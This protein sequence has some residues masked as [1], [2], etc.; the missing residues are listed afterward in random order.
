MAAYYAFAHTYGSNTIDE[1]GDHI[2][3]VMVFATRKERDA[4][5]AEGTPYVN[6]SGARTPLLVKDRRDRRAIKR[7]GYFGF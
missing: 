7:Y 3:T 5:V 6:N 4:W 2:G 1:H